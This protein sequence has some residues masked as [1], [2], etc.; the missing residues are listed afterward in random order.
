MGGR[1]WVVTLIVL[2]GCSARARGLHRRPWRSEKPPPV[3]AAGKGCT[4][5]GDLLALARRALALAG[6]VEARIVGCAAGR[7]PVPGWAAV[8]ETRREGTRAPGFH[9]LVTV[10]LGAPDGR[11]LARGAED[12]RSGTDAP[13]RTCRIE[14][15]DAVDFDGDGTDEVV[16]MCLDERK[17]GADK[18]LTVH[19]AQG[20]VL[21]VALRERAGWANRAEAWSCEPSVDYEDADER[22]VRTLVLARAPSSA[23][24]PCTEEELRYRLRGD[25][26]VARR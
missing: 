14:L 24:A 3:A 7:F 11:L 15:L 10:A 23:Q 16:R 21:G 25:R 5:A 2:C 26:M 17:D 4:E 22:G 8:V 9:E 19:R 12:L 1:A 18:W 13:D 20:G 6:D